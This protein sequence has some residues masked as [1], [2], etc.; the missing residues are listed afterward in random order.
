MIME[1]LDVVYMRVSDLK[2]G[3]KIINIGTV[4]R[5]VEFS[6]I[7]IVHVNSQH[8]IQSMNFGRFASVYVMAVNGTKNQ[9]PA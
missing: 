5:V 2:K 4:I 1:K 7:N 6:N 9:K 8:E 3:M